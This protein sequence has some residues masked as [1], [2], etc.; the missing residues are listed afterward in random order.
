LNADGIAARRHAAL[1]AT[2]LAVSRC[3]GDLQA[4]F[5]CVVERAGEI[6]PACELAVIEVVEGTELVYRSAAPTG[7]IGTRLRLAGSAS[8]LCLSLGRPLR[9]D[10]A[11]TDDRVDR[12]ACRA[13]AIRSMVLVPIA[14]QATTIGVL[15]LA[16]SRPQV[17]S[18]KTCCWDSC[19]WA[20]FLPA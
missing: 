18:R 3:G 1:I 12:A 6:V 2:Q 17:S 13:N 8:G 20:S 5:R 9:V 14:P 10:D 16:C 19:W 7:S 11:E 4:A 15:K